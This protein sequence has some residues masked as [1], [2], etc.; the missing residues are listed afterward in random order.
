[1]KISKVLIVDD[2]LLGRISVKKAIEH[3][4]WDIIEAADGFEALIKIENENPD[5]IFLDLLMPKLNGFQ[6]I[7]EMNKRGNTVP[8]IVV[9]ADIQES[10]ITQCMNAGAAGYLNKPIER[11]NLDSLLNDIT[12]I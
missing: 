10:T 8:V 3:L 4:K 2:S 1:M 5:L 7:E 6:V 12:G 9:S 11:E